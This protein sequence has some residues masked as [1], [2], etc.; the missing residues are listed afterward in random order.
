MYVYRVYPLAVQLLTLRIALEEQIDPSFSRQQEATI[1]HLNQLQPQQHQIGQ[2]HVV[3]AQQQSQ[4]QGLGEEGFDVAAAAVAASNDSP[5]PQTSEAKSP[6]TSSN[7]LTRNG[8]PLSNTKRAAQNRSAQRAFRQR[9]DAYIKDLEE[10]VKEVDA[11]KQTIETLK[12]ENIQLKDYSLALQAKLIEQP[13]V[14]APPVVFSTRGGN[15]K[16]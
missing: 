4:S 15:K 1:H 6:E 16:D 3:P 5:H 8:R 14:Q 7:P 12:Q 11:L 10:K 13:D 9:K 2:Q